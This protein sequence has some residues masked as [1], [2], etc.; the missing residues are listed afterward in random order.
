MSVN[1]DNTSL[2]AGEPYFLMVRGDRSTTLNSNTAIGPNTVLRVSGNL[3]TGDINLEVSDLNQGDGLYNLIGNPYQAVLN[4]N[5]VNRTGLTDYIYVWDASIGGLNGVGGYVSVE[6]SS[7]NE[8]VVAPGL[9]SSDA[10]QFIAPGQA[11]FVHNDADVN[12]DSTISI[13]ESD[14]AVTENQVTVF[15]TYPHFYINS[16]LFKTSDYQMGETPC[17][18]IGLRFSSFY[19][20]TA[21]SEDAVK[22]FNTNENYAIINNGYRSIVKQ[23]IPDDNH[24]VKL[25]ISNYTSTHYTL[26]FDIDNQPDNITVLLKDYYMNAETVLTGNDSYTFL[27]NENIPE[28]LAFNRFSLLFENTNLSST[29]NNFE[30]IIINPNPVTHGFFNIKSPNLIG[31]V[32]VVVTNL[33]GQLLYNKQLLAKDNQIRVTLGEPSSGIYIVKLTQDRQTFVSKIFVE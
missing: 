14:K 1:T 5:Q 15:N 7:G 26:T 29:E 27:V 31:Q 6:L 25:D 17:D 3:I 4:F 18:A 32:N 21:D 22:F 2:I 8:T 24:E 12:T 13:S 11:F 33:L 20:T 10:S 23:N 16:N 30:D 28:S 9:G 19:S